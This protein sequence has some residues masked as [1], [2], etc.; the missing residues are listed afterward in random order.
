MRQ[1]TT[2]GDTER[3]EGKEIQGRKGNRGTQKQENT[4]ETKKR[5]V[6]TKW[7]GR[8]RGKKRRHGRKR[9]E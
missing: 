4:G 3:Q 9:N 6:E 1:Q 5:K 8:K 7:G 2:P